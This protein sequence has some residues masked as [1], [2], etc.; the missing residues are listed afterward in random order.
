MVGLLFVCSLPCFFV[1]LC[2]VS[3]IGALHRDLFPFCFVV[4]RMFLSCVWVL[5]LG[6]GEFNTFWGLR[7]CL[8]W[9][10]FVLGFGGFSIFGVWGF[11]CF[12]IGRFN[13]F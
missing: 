11:F 12:G 1:L 5:V 9:G 3:F 13:V 6:L 4:L 10:F 8:V 7:F 2:W